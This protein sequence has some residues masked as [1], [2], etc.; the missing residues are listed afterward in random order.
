MWRTK[1]TSLIYL[2]QGKRLSDHSSSLTTSVSQPSS[3]GVSDYCRR[4]TAASTRASGDTIYKVLTPII[5]TRQPQRP[6]CF[7]RR[8]VSCLL[9]LGGQWSRVTLCRAW[10]RNHHISIAGPS[11]F[12]HTVP[13][14]HRSSRPGHLACLPR[15]PISPM[16]MWPGVALEPHGNDPNKAATS[17]FSS[18]T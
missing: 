17:H 2:H 14:R 16:S 4:N 5:P 1:E 3:S 9:H 18:L 7:E 11:H 10:E 15:V 6:L 13:C 8:A 12:L